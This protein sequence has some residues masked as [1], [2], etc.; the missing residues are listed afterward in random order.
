MSGALNGL[1][2]LE[3]CVVSQ[4]ICQRQHGMLIG[5]RNTSMLCNMQTD[6]KVKPSFHGPLNM[7]CAHA[8]ETMCMVMGDITVLIYLYK[9]VASIRIVIA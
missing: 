2:L 7:L 5:M 4:A 6:D 9:H 8:C 1:F 3:A